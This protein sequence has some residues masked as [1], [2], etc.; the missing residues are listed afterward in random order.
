M[1][2]V[3]NNGAFTRNFRHG[4][5]NEMNRVRTPKKLV[6]EG[7]ILI[8][9]DKFQ[10]LQCDEA[11]AV[12]KDP[13]GKLY[14]VCQ[15]G[16]HFL[17]QQRMGNDYVGFLRMPHKLDNHEVKRVAGYGRNNAKKKLITLAEAK[18]K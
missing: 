2:H 4:K 17:S 8:A 5:D 10:C 13:K 3:P 9:D 7:T 6:R 11:V 12:L 16:R 18:S 15:D 14:V 1:Y